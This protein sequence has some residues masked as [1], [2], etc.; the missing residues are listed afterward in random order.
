MNFQ[1]IANLIKIREY[2]EMNVDN[3]Y[4]KKS[5]SVNFTKL[6]SKIDEKLS[7]LLQSQNFSDLLENY[8]K[9]PNALRKI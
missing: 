2:V 4:I 6:L 8:P 5:E 3:L 7:V 1:E 9:K